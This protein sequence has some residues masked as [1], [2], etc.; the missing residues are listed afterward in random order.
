M[1]NFTLLILSA[2]LAAIGANASNPMATSFSFDECQG[3]YM[4]YPEAITRVEVPDS[5]T[6]VMINHVGRHGARYPSSPSRC[7]LIADALKRADSLGTITPDGKKLAA[8]VGQII[9]LSEGRWGALDSL[10]EAEQRGIASRMYFNFPEVFSKAKVKA[11]SSYV[12]RCMMSMYSFTHQLD[13][14][15]NK[16]EFTTTTGRQNNTLLRPFHE[17]KEYVELRRTDKL[18]APWEAYTAEFCPLSAIERVLGKNYAYAS[19]EEKRSLA[20]AEF[21]V[22]AAMSAMGLQSRLPEF[23]TIEEAN[24]LWSC[25]NLQQYLQRTAT[26]ISLV[27]AEITS[28]LILDL[29]STADDYLNGL[30]DNAVVLRF[31]HA[32]TMMPL[33]SQMRLRGC[34]YMTNYFDTVG[35]HWQNFYVVP[36]ASNLQLIFFKSDK[37]NV[38]V[39]A[40]LN[41]QPVPLIP[42]K[43]AIYTPWPE[44]RDYL[45]R[46]VSVM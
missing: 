15:S 17:D 9:S 6:P 18:T 4:P 30:S 22:V 37:G 16:M 46:C 32:E 23:F 33:L 41:E 28:A 3:S 2:L 1:R 10:G 13:R 39:R 40:D 14:L 24:A 35:L 27:P 11:I 43:D 20:L 19:P 21:H 34:Y 38:Y 8:V 12:P 44:A 5:L 29:I 26:T 42:G 25:F 45:T 7:R 36:M 31:G